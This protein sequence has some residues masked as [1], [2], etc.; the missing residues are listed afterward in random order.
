MG[1]TLSFSQGSWYLGDLVKNG[2]ALAENPNEAVVTSSNKVRN[3]FRDTV[4]VLHLDELNIF[5]VRK[6]FTRA[7]ES[8]HVPRDSW[9]D[10]RLISLG[11]AF[12]V[13]LSAN[14]QVRVVFSGTSHAAGHILRF[15][16]ELK[17]ANIP[18][19]SETDPR[20]VEGVLKYFLDTSIVDDEYFTFLCKELSG[21]ARSV[22]WF[23]Q[24][25][26][27]NRR[28][29]QGCDLSRKDFDGALQHARDSFFSQCT[30]NLLPH[31]T[32]ASHVANDALLAFAFCEQYGGQRDDHGITFHAGKVPL[33]WKNWSEA[34]AIHLLQLP[35]GSGLRLQH[36]YPF[37]RDFL[38]TNAN[39]V[40][41]HDK[42]QFR[43][44]MNSCLAQPDTFPGVVFQFA[45]ALELKNSKSALWAF[46]CKAFPSLSLTPL[47][48]L[49]PVQLFTLFNEVSLATNR[50]HIYMVVDKNSDGARYVDVCCNVIEYLPDG[51]S[52]QV[53]IK[54]EVKRVQNDAVLRKKALDY[55]EKCKG[56][57][58]D[59]AVNLFLS[60]YPT[61]THA[62][63]MREGNVV[64]SLREIC[65]QPRF[66]ILEGPQ[67]FAGCDLPFAAMTPSSAKDVGAFRRAIMKAV[68]SPTNIRRTKAND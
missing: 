34:G 59:T 2:L 66:A 51:A 41:S 25:I 58:D 53:A 16:T 50:E 9:N 42:E 57:Q 56:A 6:E 61:R 40:H 22:Q 5:A 1:C 33:E 54:I 15:P 30:D 7:A 10:Y 21:C 39:L 52:R 27:V 18:P 63:N 13:A 19:L 31:G 48:Y 23:L 55:F 64:K 45:V 43:D 68:G 11:D 29:V 32:E 67:C 3:I 12:H 14:R 46:I 35:G 65:Q 36:P 44:F 8:E 17:M 20:F 28:S 49:P 60:Y 24:H 4:L 26:S 37:L 47:N 62:D 38:F